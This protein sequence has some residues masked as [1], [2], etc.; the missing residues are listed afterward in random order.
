MQKRA[1]LMFAPGHPFEL[2]DLMPQ[3][4]LA[5]LASALAAGGHEVEIADLGNA[6]YAGW[7]GAK[8]RPHAGAIESYGAD[9]LR[10]TQSAAAFDVAVV[11]VNH[12]KDIELAQRM[13]ADLGRVAPK[14]RRFLTGSP[15][16]HFRTALSPAALHFDAVLEDVPEMELPA[17][18]AGD[19]PLPSRVRL[20]DLP[21][22]CYDHKTYPALHAPGKL[23][24]F[25]LEHARGELPAGSGP[26][27]PWHAP[28]QR[29]RSASRLAEEWLHLTN[30]FSSLRGANIAGKASASEV[31]GTGY[32]LRSLAIP[33][34]SCRELS[35]EQASE[36]VLQSLV[37]SGCRA[38][39]LRLDTGSQRLLDRV[40]AHGFMVSQAE[41]TLR[42]A[43]QHGLRTAV[44]MTYPGPFDDYHTRAESMRIL[45]RTR[46]DSVRVHRPAPCPGSLWWE[47]PEKYGFS[48][49][50]AALTRHAIFASPCE[51]ERKKTMVYLREL[52][53]LKIRIGH[54]AEHH[55]LRSLIGEVPRAD[56]QL[57]RLVRALETGHATRVG[58]LVEAFNRQMSRQARFVS[59]EPFVPILA[60][61]G[62]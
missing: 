29:V 39:H 7:G 18:L 34:Q 36:H 60:A 54:G 52:R 3:R 50:E 6:R 12:S 44:S 10:L 13:G 51:D 40:Y 4:R 49:E 1:L 19:S 46:P 35:F 11:L 55:L 14:C 24:L 16:E 37:Q 41:R 33:M 21:H 9:M 43:H 59:M 25:T 2:S 15:V 31:I 23:N 22:P 30:S 38:I 47:N 61:V 45:S 42:T 32:E 48:G 58:T 28:R 26:A 56:Q 57:R 8:S 5:A 20:D 27:S 62:N 53:E 17:L